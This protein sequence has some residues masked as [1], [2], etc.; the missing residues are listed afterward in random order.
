MVGSSSRMLSCVKD[1]SV[2]VSYLLQ[3]PCKLHKLQLTMFNSRGQKHSYKHEQ[4]T[5]SLTW[6]HRQLRGKG[7]ITVLSIQSCHVQFLTNYVQKGN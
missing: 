4:N 7:S 1:M 3:G 2:S 5:E 6:T